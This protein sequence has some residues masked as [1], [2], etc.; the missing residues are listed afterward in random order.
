MRVDVILGLQWGD[1]GKGKIVDF[2]ADKY[3]IIARFQGGPNAGHTL[4]INGTKRV[5]HTIPS[6]IFRKDCMNLIGN[7]VVIDPIT[8]LKEI[9]TLKADGIP[10]EDRLII[11]KRANLILPTHKIL[12]AASETSK[13]NAKIGSTLKGIGPTYMDK[14][15]RNGLRIGD[16]LD[17]DFMTKYELLKNKHLS[18]LQIYQ[19]DFELEEMEEEWLNAISELK[20]LKLVESTY[21][22]QEALKNGKKN[23]GRRRTRHYAGY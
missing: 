6:G 23:S 13:G 20:K 4:V 2:L 8:L 17:E 16:I 14:T 15:G 18:L 3:E 21:Y 7:G 19:F 1:E 9:N 10:V 5:L 11:A 12:D 22:I